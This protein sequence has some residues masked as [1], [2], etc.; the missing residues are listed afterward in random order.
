MARKK[1]IPLDEIIEL[2]NEGLYDQEIADIIGCCRSN[3][4]IRLNKAGITD[5]HGKLDDL[6]LRSRI[7]DSLIG[8]Y[9]GENDPN[10]KGAM[11]EKGL[12]RGLY[13]TV[14]KRVRRERGEVCQICGS[15]DNICVHHIKPFKIIFDEFMNN[16]YSGNIETF[17]DELM[18]YPDFIDEN[19]LV[20]ICQKCH[21]R[22]HYTDDPDLSPYRWERATTIESIS[23]TLKKQVE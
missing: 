15:H 3:I 23:A 8:R 11:D 17:Y 14:A 19:N 2:H 22:I 20:V 10:Y 12:A 9:V 21:R 4:T 16:A 5:R 6:Y 7:S 1:M 18:S 13:R